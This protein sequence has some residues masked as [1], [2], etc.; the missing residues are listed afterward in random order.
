MAADSTA[1][2][3]A[4]VPPAAIAALRQN[5]SLAAQFDAKYGQGFAQRVLGGQ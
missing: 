5:P 1:A 3:G 2:A 4:S